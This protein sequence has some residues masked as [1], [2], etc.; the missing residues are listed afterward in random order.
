MHLH[1][2]TQKN[3]AQKGNSLKKL[4]ETEDKMSKKKRILDENE[5]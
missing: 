5:T 1:S 4:H 3:L 2:Q